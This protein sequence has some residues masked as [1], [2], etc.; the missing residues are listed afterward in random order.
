MMNTIA[1]SGR[2]RNAVGALAVTALP[3]VA[4]LAACGTKDTLLE[5][6]D[7]DIIDPIAVNSVEGAQALYYGALGRLRQATGGSAGEGSSWLFGGLLADEWST[8]CLTL[9]I[10]DCQRLAE[11][12]SLVL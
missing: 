9:G 12:W 3:L 6:T 10:E 8:S 4:T 5:A 2:L 7:P 11:S 1:L